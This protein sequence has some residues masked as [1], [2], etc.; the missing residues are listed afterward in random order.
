MPDPFK[1]EGVNRQ[2]AFSLSP[3]VGVEE[4]VLAPLLAMLRSLSRNQANFEDAL[5]QSINVIGGPGSLPHPAQ[6]QAPIFMLAFIP[7]VIL[8]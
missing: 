2:T 8:S 4:A 7:R 1:A 3:Y 6:T 5:P